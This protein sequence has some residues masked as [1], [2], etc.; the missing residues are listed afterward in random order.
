MVDVVHIAR[1]NLAIATRIY[2]LEPQWNPYVES[3]AMGRALRLDQTDQVVITRY[4]M[5]GTIETVSR[6]NLHLGMPLLMKH[7]ATFTTSR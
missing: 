7:R 4:L 1:L 5:E 6:L 2:L 3:Q